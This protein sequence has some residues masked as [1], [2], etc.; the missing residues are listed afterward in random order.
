[1]STLIADPRH[2]VA[3]Q[4]D[5]SLM[6]GTDPYEVGFCVSDYCN[7]GRSE[8]ASYELGGGLTAF[9]SY[10]LQRGFAVV[11]RDLNDRELYASRVA[12]EVEIRGVL[13]N[14]LS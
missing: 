10:S 6:T 14:Y 4:V 13:S 1:M 8:V 2:R 5:P 3:E 7:N 9:I 11:I 12:D